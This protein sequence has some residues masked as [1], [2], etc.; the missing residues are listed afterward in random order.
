MRII[1]LGNNRG[2]LQVLQWLVQQGEKIVGLVVHPPERQKYGGEIISTADLPAARVFNGD[3]LRSEQTL[4]RIRALQ[5][6]IGL[7]VFFGHILSPP[8]LEMFPL[9]CINLHPAFLPYNRG[10]YPNVWSIVEG[11]PAGA[12]LHYVDAGVDT[13]DI[14]AQ[15]QV[16][17]H[18][19]DTGERLYQRLE[20]VCVELF[21]DTWPSVRSGQAPRH[22]QDPHDGTVHRVR[23]V[24]RLDAIDPGAKYTARELIDIVRARTFPPYRGAYFELE[25][26]RIYLRLQLLSEEEMEEGE[27]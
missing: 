24:E 27:S 16:P 6:D 2:G 11:T 1:Y 20:Q 10:A 4:R 5:P 23:D 13:G 26:K 18:P 25:G 7:S 17:V 21:Q 8:F 12:T 14:I 3:T 19:T 9:G 22:S 15:R